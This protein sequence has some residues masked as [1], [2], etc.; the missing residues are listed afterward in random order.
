MDVKRNKYT[1]TNLA[2]AGAM[3]INHFYIGNDKGT[4]HEG[5]RCIKAVNGEWKAAQENENNVTR[6]PTVSVR[7]D[8]CFRRA[9]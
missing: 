6:L 7:D 4:G 1:G 9:I 3:R 2:R 5:D 8:E